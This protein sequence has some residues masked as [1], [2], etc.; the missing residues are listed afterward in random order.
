MEEKQHKYRTCERDDVD[1]TK[2]K[3]R[4]TTRNCRTAGPPWKI[5]MPYSYAV[6][7]DAGER[8]QRTAGE[9]TDGVFPTDF[10]SVFGRDRGPRRLCAVTGEN[11]VGKRGKMPENIRYDRGT[12]HVRPPRTGS[13]LPLGVVRC[14]AWRMACPTTTTCSFRIH[15]CPTCGTR[16]FFVPPPPPPPPLPST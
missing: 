7:Q 11:A 2:H 15:W 16:P 14:A 1:N 10:C 6:A 13:F 8:G 5:P 9:P 4:R 3:A 12:A